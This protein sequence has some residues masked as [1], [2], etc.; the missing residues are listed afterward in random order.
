M[1]K[2]A[3][4][5]DFHGNVPATEA[6]FEDVARQNVDEILVGG[7][8][9]GRGPEGCRVV[10]FIRERGWPCVL[11]NHE[12]Y[13]LNFRHR[14]VPED[15]WGSEEWAAA[16]WMAAELD[17]VAV[18]YIE[19]LPFSVT[20]TSAPGLRLVHGSPRSCNEGLGPWCS[21]D[22]LERQLGEI[23]ETLLVC[24]HTHRPLCRRVASG[25]V[26]NV[27]SVGLPFNRDR[28]AQYAI[29]HHDG[30]GW[31]VEFR[32]VPYDVDRVLD[33]YDATGF[34]VRGGVTARLLR[35]EVEQAAPFLVPFLKWA[36]A[37][38]VSPQLSQLDPFLDFYDPD[39]P[40]HELVA[41]LRRL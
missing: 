31:D 6:A 2:I 38:G 3:V 30:G 27:G 29:L 14:R 13:L 17:D 8:L 15:W 23:G 12:E 4:L 28:R 36:A 24:G 39:E 1:K 19:S 37:C 25:M 7:D 40:V 11:G 10:H 16:R 22:E 32:Q 21:D 34:L 20:A 33:V 18:R 41:R 5:S 26:V 35:L 9:V